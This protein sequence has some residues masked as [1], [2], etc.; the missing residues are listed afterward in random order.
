MQ[1]P[2]GLRRGPLSERNYAV[3]G[4]FGCSAHPWQAGKSAYHS[5]LLIT[6][7]LEFLGGYED[8][9]EASLAVV[10][11]LSHHD[12][13]SQGEFRAPVNLPSGFTGT[14]F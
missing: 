2:A 3:T 10:N 8:Q 1:W 14:V 11:D 13:L 5:V 6:G 9:L 7:S 12:T 4:P